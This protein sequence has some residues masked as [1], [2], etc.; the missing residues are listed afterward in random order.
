MFQQRENKDCARNRRAI[1]RL[2]HH[3]SKRKAIRFARRLKQTC[4]KKNKIGPLIDQN[5]R[6]KNTKKTNANYYL[7]QNNQIVLIRLLRFILSRVAFYALQ[8]KKKI[9]K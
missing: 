3:I 9:A 1:N 6:A 4:Q 2:S 7:S 8:T 5:R